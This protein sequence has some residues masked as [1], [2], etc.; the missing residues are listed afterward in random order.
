MALYVI[1]R[2]A[3]GL[4]VCQLPSCDLSEI[5]PTPLYDVYVIGTE[6]CERSIGKSVVFPSKVLFSSGLN[7]NSYDCVAGK[8]GSQVMSS[9]G[10]WLC[11]RR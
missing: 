11:S 9:N 2:T 7:L 10:K 1:R 4:T 5:L 6:E 8:M 3:L